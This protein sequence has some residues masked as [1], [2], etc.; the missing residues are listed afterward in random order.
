[1]AAEVW[2]MDMVEQVEQVVIELLAVG[3]V[4]FKHALQLYL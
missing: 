3:Q 1:V 2:D 4:H